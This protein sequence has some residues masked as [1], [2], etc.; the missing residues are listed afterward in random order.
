MTKAKA[1]ADIQ[2]AAAK[3]AIVAETAA[4]KTEL[5]QS[6]QGLADQIATSLLSGRR[7]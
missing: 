2:L 7:A 5:A 1:D 4:A 3:K 6:S